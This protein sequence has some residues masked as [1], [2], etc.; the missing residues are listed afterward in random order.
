MIRKIQR[1][2]RHSWL[3]Y[4]LRQFVIYKT[5]FKGVPVVVIDLRNTSRQCSKCGY[6]AK[7]NRKNQAEFCCKKCGYNENA[8]YNVVKNIAARAVLTNPLSSAKKLS[9]VA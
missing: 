2:K 1:A 6:I 9:K 4:Q 3:F 5:K 7:A 8:D